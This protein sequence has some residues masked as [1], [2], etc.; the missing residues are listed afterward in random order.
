MVIQTQVPCNSLEIAF[1]ADIVCFL[2]I[3]VRLIRKFDH[4]MSYRSGPIDIPVKKY[5]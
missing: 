3:P 4:E 1:S 5:I 2:F